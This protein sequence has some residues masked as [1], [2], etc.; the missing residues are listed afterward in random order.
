MGRTRMVLNRGRR[1]PDVDTF[2]SPRAQAVRKMEQHGTLL[3]AFAVV[4]Y[5][6]LGYVVFHRQKELAAAFVWHSSPIDW[7]EQNYTHSNSIC[8]WWNTM[9]STVMFLPALGG[10]RWYSADVFTLHEPMFVFI[11]VAVVALFLGA[12]LFHATLS[13]AG[14]VFDELPLVLLLVFGMLMMQPLHVWNHQ[15]RSFI[16]T[17]QIMS[18]GNAAFAVFCLLYPTLSHV[19]TVAS[20]PIV[21]IL[22]IRAFSQSKHKPWGMLVEV[23]IFLAVAVGAWILDRVACDSLR[24]LA[25]PVLGFPLQLHTLWHVCMAMVLWMVIQIG[26]V[27]RLSGDEK[28]FHIETHF[29]ILPVV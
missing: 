26:L 15:V 25:V 21:T 16:F 20:P 6:C 29:W 8:E 3:T 22:V 1:C 19:V 13:I 12:W 11:W 28:H 17:W 24:A 14:Q 27:I 4:A 9:S 23:L 2:A 10:W 7:C 5:A 18:C